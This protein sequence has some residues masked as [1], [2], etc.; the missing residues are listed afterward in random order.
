LLDDKSERVR[1]LTVFTLRCLGPAADAALPALIKCLTDPDFDIKD[2]SVTA[3]GTIHEQPE[4]VVP[5]IMNFLEANRANTILRKDA[6]IALGQFKEQAK[7]A[8]PM[9]IGFLN[10]PDP[11]IR[12]YATNALRQIDPASLPRQ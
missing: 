1:Y 7:P 4:L 6:I 9:L 5:L 8:V 12:S 11:Q 2:D 10:D 3:M